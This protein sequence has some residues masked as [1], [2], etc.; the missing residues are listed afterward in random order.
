MLQVGRRQGTMEVIQ[1]VLARMWRV[2]VVRR[3]VRRWLVRHVWSYCS[4]CWK[5]S[6]FSPTGCSSALVV[7]VF[8]VGIWKFGHCRMHLWG[9]QGSDSA[10]SVVALARSWIQL[11]VCLTAFLLPLVS[12][13]F[14]GF[15]P[16]QVPVALAISNLCQGQR[17]EACHCVLY[18]SNRCS[19]SVSK[20][21]YL[22]V[23]P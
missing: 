1:E 15:R 6:R 8:D 10:A 23:A 14:S 13:E 3:V 12:L 20:F 9:E 11:G 19:F 5:V 17:K 18:H 16:L 21:S 7:R 22:L 4:E 2:A